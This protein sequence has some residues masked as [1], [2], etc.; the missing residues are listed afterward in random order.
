MGTMVI[1]AAARLGVMGGLAVPA[2][3][4]AVSALLFAVAR[5]RT[6]GVSLSAMGV[7]AGIWTAGRA[8]RRGAAVRLGRR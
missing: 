2:L 7:G 5:A 4:V 3:V 6:L 1:S 8:R